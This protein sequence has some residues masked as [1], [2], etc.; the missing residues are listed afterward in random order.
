MA[1]LYFVKVLD[2]AV[3]LLDQLGHAQRDKK[4]TETLLLSISCRRA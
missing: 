2:I 4:K 1:K 3:S